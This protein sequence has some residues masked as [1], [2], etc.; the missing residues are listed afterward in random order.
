M[1]IV[2][3][4]FGSKNYESGIKK[5]DVRDTIFQLQPDAAPFV[6]LLQKLPKIKAVDTTVKWFEDDLLGN[7]TQINHVGGY[8]G[9]ATDLVVDDA[10]IFEIGDVAKVVSTNECM[11]VTGVNDSTQT[12]TVVRGWGVQAGAVMTDDAYVYKLGSAQAEG[13]SPAN[14][15]VTAKVAKTNFLQIFS[16]SVQI[17]ETADNIAVYGGNRMD[18]E[19]KK[20]GIE[21]KREIESQFLFGEPKEDTTGTQN[22]WQTGG[23][24]YF[25]KGTAPELN[26][27]SA[28]L[29]ES[30]WEGFLKDLFLY[31]SSEKYFFTGPLILSQISQFATG[32]QRLEPG[33][34]TTYG[35]KVNKYHSANGDVNLVKDL[36][37]I[38]PFAGYGFGLDMDE[39]VYR[40]LQGTD[41]QLK[42]K[43]QEKKAH[44]IMDE[45][46]GHIGLEIHQAKQ[47]GIL[48]GVA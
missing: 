7:Y 21:L 47:H 33:V 34:T 1:A 12:I 3:D 41:I 39:L 17:T 5:L 6:T 20:K 24:Y 46:F 42:L 11:R 32:K 2:R 30:A 23:V 8:D 15:T 35:V 14:S 25:I 19:R 43:V 44:Y 26:M 29:T 27:N 45:Y 40:Y 37:F 16:K 18:L 13:W 28:A 48:Y 31:G 36:H 10:G 9:A 4:L 22:R 38:G